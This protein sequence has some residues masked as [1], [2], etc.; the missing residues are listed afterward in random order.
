MLWQHCWGECRLQRQRTVAK[1]DRTYGLSPGRRERG[2]KPDGYYSMVSGQLPE[3]GPRALVLYHR[4]YDPRTRADSI[5]NE[6]G[7]DYLRSIGRS[8]DLD[9]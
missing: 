1:G 6:R 4:A 9:F 5:P 3:G 8:F 7:P 2:H